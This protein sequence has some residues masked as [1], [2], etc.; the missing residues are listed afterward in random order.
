M[1]GYV[2]VCVAKYVYVY[3]QRRRLLQEYMRQRNALEPTYDTEC[4]HVQSACT[5][6]MHARTECVH[7]QNACTYRMHAYTFCNLPCMFSEMDHIFK[8]QTA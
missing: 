8:S 5:Y 1:Y 4:V 3:I 7:V 2:C 6:R